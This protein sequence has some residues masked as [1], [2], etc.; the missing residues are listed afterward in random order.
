[1]DE[2]AGARFLGPMLDGHVIHSVRSHG[3]DVCETGDVR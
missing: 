1:M 2:P 3:E